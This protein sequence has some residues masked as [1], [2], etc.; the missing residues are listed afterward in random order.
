MSARG[1]AEWLLGCIAEDE[2]VARA[3]QTV[4]LERVEWLGNNRWG[5]AYLKRVPVEEVTTW[6]SFRGSEQVSAPTDR[7]EHTEG[8]ALHQRFNPAHVLAVCEAHRRIVEEHPTGNPSTIGPGYCE[9]CTD[10]TVWDDYDIRYPGGKH[11]PCPTLRALATAYADRPGFR[12]EWR[13]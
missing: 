10:G 5:K 2:R 8:S 1:L 11:Y 4:G 13:V 12:E 9:T 6:V 7:G 3:A